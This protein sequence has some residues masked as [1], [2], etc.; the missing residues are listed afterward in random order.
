[1]KVFRYL[2]MGVLCMFL[3]SCKGTYE[4][5]MKK[6]LCQPEFQITA[7]IY[8][9][10]VPVYSKKCGTLKGY[11]YIERKDS[12]LFKA[13][14]E[15]CKANDIQLKSIDGVS[16]WNFS[17]EKIIDTCAVYFL[18]KG[19]GITYDTV[20]LDKRDDWYFTRPD[21]YEYIKTIIV[22]KQVTADTTKTMGFV[23]ITTNEP[24]YLNYTQSTMDGGKWIHFVISGDTVEL[25]NNQPYIKVKTLC[26]DINE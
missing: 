18:P 23:S 17:E 7:T 24:I 21:I 22:E 5:Y 15:F 2:T 16:L 12:L 1:M 10:E 14:Q 20:K 11:E 13:V 6:S 25:Y 9:A 4:D 8:E 3:Y 19:T 26:T